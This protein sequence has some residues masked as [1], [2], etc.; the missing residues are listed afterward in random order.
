MI[1]VEINS[2]G[3]WEMVFKRKN[4]LGTI[5]RARGNHDNF[6]TNKNSIRG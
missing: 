1:I 3:S 2:G 6:T 4:W 5:V